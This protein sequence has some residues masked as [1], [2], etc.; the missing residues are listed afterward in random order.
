MPLIDVPLP[1]QSLAATQNAIRQNFLDLSPLVDGVDNYVL[2]PVQVTPPSTS[3]TQMALYS[4]DVAGVPQLFLRG[5]SDATPVNISIQE[6]S[7]G[8]SCIYHP[9]G[10]K[11]QWGIASVSAASPTVITLP[12]AYSSTNY[13]ISVTVGGNNVNPTATVGYNSNG[14]SIA[15]GSF[16]LRTDSVAA[17][18]VR[19]MT[20]GA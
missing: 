4:E 18:Q 3:A 1:G 11:I 5:A 9:S 8:N 20:I 14:G 13:S 17:V 6:S 15:N 12:V 2:L 19:W 7:G 10:V 16:Q